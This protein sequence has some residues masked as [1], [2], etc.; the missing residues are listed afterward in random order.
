METIVDHPGL[1][2]SKAAAL[3]WPLVLAAG[4]ALAGAAL[5]LVLAT[6]VD[7]SPDEAHYALFG[8]HP[9]WSYFDHPAL[10]GWLQAPFADDDAGNLSMRIVPMVAWLLSVVLMSRLVSRLPS[11]T[12]SAFESRRWDA[13]WVAV[14]L[15]ASPLPFLLGVALVPDTLLMPLVPATM[16]AT[17]RLRD[18]AQSMRLGRWL[19]LGAVVGLALLAKYTGV[20]LAIGAFATLHVFH[21]RP[22][23]R[24]RGPWA[25]LFLAALLATPIVAW[26]ASHGWAS[27]CYQ[28]D[29]ATGRGE[30]WRLV[31]MLRAVL[32]QLLLLGIPT[33]VA[34]ARARPAPSARIDAATRDA[35]R[36]CW[37]FGL[38]VLVVFAAMAGYGASLPHWTTCGWMALLP[39]AVAGLH[40]IRLAVVAATLGWQCA[41]LAGLVVLVTGAGLQAEEGAARVTRAGVRAPGARP[42]PIADLHGWPAAAQHADALASRF[43]ARGLVVMN[44]SLA[45]RI[46]WY[47]RPTPVFVA[48]PRHDQFELWFG[49][50]QRGD[51]A[52]VIDW[53]GLPLPVPGGA[54]GFRECHPIDQM[55]VLVDGRQIAHF[56]FLHCQGWSDPP[57]AH[58]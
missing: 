40:R 8:A 21:G 5:H 32:L 26:N 19:G 18:P 51:D 11:L 9:D 33:W 10:T 56:N 14:L 16:L 4:I 55:P 25:A 29:H 35:R 49:R 15:V 57:G 12:G 24:R 2:A 39:L 44:W 41:L 37:I 47:A 28:A 38:P 13:A 27:I 58:T 54:T 34:I 52:I 22:L 7:L 20:F 23:W 42:N 6:Q 1:R 53:S 43:Q 31:P 36:L 3:A 46:A 30:P 45:S 17:W 50:L 48:P